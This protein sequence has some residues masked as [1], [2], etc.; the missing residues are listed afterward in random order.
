MVS[1][2]SDGGNTR[3]TTWYIHNS[4]IMEIMENA[5]KKSKK[6]KEYKTR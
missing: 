1:D 4:N 2:N 6:G 3:Y 5:V